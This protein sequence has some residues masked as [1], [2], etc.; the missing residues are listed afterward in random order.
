ML[1][2]SKLIQKAIKQRTYPEI[3]IPEERIE[4]QAPVDAP[5]ATA[6][7]VQPPP[8]VDLERAHDTED[9]EGHEAHE[10]DDNG[11]LADDVQAAIVEVGQAECD[12]QNEREARVG[13]STVSI[14]E[15]A[16]VL[17]V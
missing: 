16:G 15:D 14:A 4:K 17:V 3:D 8:R 2:T 5:E 12:A 6:G 1:D 7:L 13:I 11:H 10:A 9:D